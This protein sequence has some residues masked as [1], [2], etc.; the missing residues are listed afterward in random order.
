MVIKV[1]QLIWDSWNIA[2][3][4][5]H[6][7]V[8]DEVEQVCHINPVVQKGKKGRLL[9]FGPTEKHRMLVAVLDPIEEKGVF[10]P[11]TAYSASKKLIKIYL[12]KKGGEKN[13]TNEENG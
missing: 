7:V 8:P 4:A 6:N 13:D 1:L 9:V 3:I 12:N 11:I 2:H 5:K 10:Y